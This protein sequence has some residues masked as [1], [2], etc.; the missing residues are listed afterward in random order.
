MHPATDTSAADTDNAKHPII[1]VV[2]LHEFDDPNDDLLPATT[3]EFR[4]ITRY[5]SDGGSAT[6]Y[7]GEELLV[8]TIASA[9]WS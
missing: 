2:Y 1:A 3:E 5:V 6:D 9:I 7:S 4:E 8:R